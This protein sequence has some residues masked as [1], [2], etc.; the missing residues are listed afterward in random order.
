MYFVSTN[1][2]NARAII[3]QIVKSTYILANFPPT[4]IYF[5]H[6][7][8]ESF[9]KNRLMGPLRFGIQPITHI[10]VRFKCFIFISYSF[11]I[12]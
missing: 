3:L 4:K 2:Q 8:C 11:K 7:F 10:I 5:K 9:V 12:P 1:Q 6:D